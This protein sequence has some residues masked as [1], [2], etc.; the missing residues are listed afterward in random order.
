MIIIVLLWIIGTFIIASISAI[1]AK[2]YGPE[3]II[4]MFVGCVVIANILASKIVTFLNF[5]V[6]AVVIIYST[7]FFLTDILSE[8]YGKKE[9]KKAVWSGFLANVIL[10]FNVFI[11]INWTPAPFWGNQDALVK[12]LGMTPRIVIASL[13][14]YLISQNHD[15]WA[16]NF[17]KNK[18]K[19][20]HLWLRN[21]VSTIVSQLIDSFIFITIAFIGIFPI[22]PL[23]IGQ[24]IIKAIIALLD[25]P[26]LYMVRYYYN[27]K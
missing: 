24:F 16:Y 1:I 2:K 19:G 4:G 11:I 23:I 20:K 8:F 10:V 12:I 15:V 17:L 3:Y 25:T 5:T 6:P 22:F 21:N 27:K 9:T 7:T 14:A 26:F 18:T 13:I